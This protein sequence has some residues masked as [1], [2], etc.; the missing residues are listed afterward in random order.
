MMPETSDPPFRP[1]GTL[2]L[3]RVKLR[4][5]LN[6]FLEIVAEAPVKV[7]ATAIF[8]GLIWLALYGL[9]YKVF[10]YFQMS[11][12]QSVV[13][14]PLIFH[15]FFVALLV[16]L[17][18]SN[19]IL[20]YGALFTHEE[21]AYLLAAPV[22]VRSTV[23]VKFGES[24]FFSSWS[25][26]LLGLPLMMAIAAVYDGESWSFYALFLLLFVSF[27]PIPGAL[28]LLTAWGVA[29]F[30]PHTLRRFEV[31]A[32]MAC[33][34]VMMVWGMRTVRELRWIN[35]DWLDDFFARL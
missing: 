4:A 7:L 11:L 27:V 24:L 23:L 17:T 33:L 1:A 10:D 6:H 19:A 8:I 9:F 29:R 20:M 16:L 25:L 14:I 5:L 18:L 31:Y 12:L 35:E 32:A 2:L 15:F 26:L 34:A 13:A 22:R 30:L 3:A 28:G 21:A